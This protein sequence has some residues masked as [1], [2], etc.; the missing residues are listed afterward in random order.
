MTSRSG[1]SV[2]TQRTMTRVHHGRM[3]TV[4]RWSVS[5]FFQAEDGI[6]D[7]T[8]TGVQTCALPICELA[9]M[10][11]E[12]EV[13]RLASEAAIE[14][15]DL[16]Q[17]PLLR[18]KLVRLGAEEHVLL[19]TMHHIVSDGWSVGLLINEVG[20]LYRANLAGERSPLVELPIQYG[21]YAVWQRDRKST[22]LN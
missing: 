3:P 7:L 22:R 5:F 6:R 10:E 16:G 15:F 8:V 19:V 1:V 9:G 21:D 4:W 12:Q 20:S 14:P 11:Q 18:V 2:V 17:G 13:G